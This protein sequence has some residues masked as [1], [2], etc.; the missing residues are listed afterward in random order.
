MPVAAAAV[1]AGCALSNMGA[2]NSA[3]TTA[4]VR[5]MLQVPSTTSVTLAVALHDGYAAKTE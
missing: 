4:S 5:F 3:V 1:G 2:S